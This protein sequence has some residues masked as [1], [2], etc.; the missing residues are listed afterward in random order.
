MSENCSSP[1]ICE[2]RTCASAHIESR[3]LQCP[4]FFCCHLPSGQIARDNGR[5]SFIPRYPGKYLPAS[6]PA[7]TYQMI[8]GSCTERNGVEER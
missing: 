2:A 8:N 7:V 4:V 6:V 5:E 1:Q 3:L